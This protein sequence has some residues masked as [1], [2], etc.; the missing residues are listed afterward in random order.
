MWLLVLF[1]LAGP[2]IIGLGVPQTAR[3]DLSAK[4]FW[5]VAIPLVVGVAFTVAGIWGLSTGS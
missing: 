3:L 1:L 2:V 4:R 5:S